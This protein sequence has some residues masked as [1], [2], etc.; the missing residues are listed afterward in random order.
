[1]FWTNNFIKFERYGESWDVTVLAPKPLEATRQM[2]VYKC[3]FRGDFI[4]TNS[5]IDVSH[6]SLL[7]SHWVLLQN[8]RYNETN[9]CYGSDNVCV[10]W[11]WQQHKY[12]S[13][14]KGLRCYGSVGGGPRA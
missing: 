11:W 1:M 10:I 9:D 7:L 4:Y 12:A 5:E 3:Q 14:D 2:F 13:Y 6:Y 8:Q